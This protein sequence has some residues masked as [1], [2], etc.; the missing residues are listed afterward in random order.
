MYAFRAK[1]RVL[2]SLGICLSHY[3][4][5]TLLCTWHRGVPLL[6]VLQVFEIFVAVTLYSIILTSYIILCDISFI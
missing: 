3:H 5:L 4:S 1:A 6:F 2:L